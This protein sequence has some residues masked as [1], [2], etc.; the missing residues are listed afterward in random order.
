MTVNCQR[1]DY[2]Y[3]VS[4]AHGGVLSDRGPSSRLHRHLIYTVAAKVYVR[5]RK[6]SYD[7]VSS[8][9]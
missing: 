6:G 7:L 8:D 4:E 1:C 9:F 3:W 5:G 2:T